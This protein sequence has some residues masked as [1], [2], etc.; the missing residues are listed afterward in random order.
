[1]QLS[2]TTN[3]GAWNRTIT[4]RG[5]YPLF[6]FN[7]A[8]A[9]WGAIGYDYSGGM[10]FWVNASTADTGAIS[11][12]MY[13]T[14][15]GNLGIG[16]TS[17]THK[18]EVIGSAKVDNYLNV[19]DGTSQV[20]MFADGVYG[21]G[22]MG[23]GSTIES[24]GTNRHL[25]ILTPT[26]GGPGTVSIG[27]FKAPVGA[28]WNRALSI[29]NAPAIPHLMLQPDSGNV[30]IGTTADPGH[31]LHVEGDINTSGIFRVGGVAGW[32]GTIVIATNPPG[33][34]NIQ[35]TGGIITNVS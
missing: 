27:Y 26:D 16:T 20:A 3:T 19:G 35:V 7:S 6:T 14:N 12:A 32:T 4:I 29:S 8:D 23:L 22:A 34:Q 33:Q 24:G 15:A 13:I 2:T 1:M 25:R 17:P 21:R 10:A 5:T 31:K 11:S 30:V 9:K 28:F 18:L